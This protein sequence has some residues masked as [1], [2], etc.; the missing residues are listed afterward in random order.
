VHHEVH[1]EVH[2]ANAGPDAAPVFIRKSITIPA[3]LWDHV[4]KRMKDPLHAN[5]LSSYIRTLIVGDTQ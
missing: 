1:H 5:N 2:Q 4:E 3:S